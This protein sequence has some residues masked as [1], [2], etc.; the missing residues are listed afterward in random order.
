MKYD[1]F[2]CYNS[3]DKSVVNEIVKKLGD[4]GISCWMDRF[5]LRPGVNWKKLPL[6]QV[7]PLTHGE[8]Y[9]RPAFIWQYG[10]YDLK[11]SRIL[12]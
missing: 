3:R 2:I 4:Q 7:D 6:H 1:V 10:I 11:M 8:L 12:N 5:E 9:P